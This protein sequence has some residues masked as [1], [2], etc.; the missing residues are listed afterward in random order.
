M[1]AVDLPRSAVVGVVQ[2]VA[3]HAPDTWRAAL[4]AELT[5]TERNGGEASELLGGR[6]RVD[7]PS[8]GAVLEDPAALLQWCEAHWPEALEVAVRYLD[9]RLITTRRV[10]AEVVAD[11]LS[12]ACDSGDPLPGVRVYS[13]PARVVVEVSSAAHAIAAQ[14]GAS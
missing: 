10:S 4:L 1:K 11:V 14:A 3:A 12:S 8:L 13:R 2:A 9:G 7:P 6:L 5:P